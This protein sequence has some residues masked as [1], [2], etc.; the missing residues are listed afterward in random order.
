MLKGQVRLSGDE[1]ILD[2]S[3]FVEQRLSL[4]NE[5]KQRQY[6]L[7]SEG[8]DLNRLAQCVSAHLQ[9]VCRSA[10]HPRTLSE[11]CEATQRT[12]LSCRSKIGPDSHRSGKKDGFEPAGDLHGGQAERGDTQGAWHGYRW[13][14]NFTY[15]LMDVPITSAPDRSMSW[16]P[17]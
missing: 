5:R 11:H 13:F 8:V 7:G 6:R 2:D 1:R 3:D 12:M 10:V 16:V 17:Y 4:S 15:K 14:F 9:P